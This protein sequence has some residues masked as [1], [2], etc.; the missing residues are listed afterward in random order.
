MFVKCIIALN[1]SCNHEIMYFT[2]FKQLKLYLTLLLC[3]ATPLFNND[4]SCTVEPVVLW[5]VS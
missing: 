4:T 3:E 1:K 5:K 2:F